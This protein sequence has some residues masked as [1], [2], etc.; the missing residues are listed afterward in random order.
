MSQDSDFSTNRHSVND[1]AKAQVDSHPSRHPDLCFGD[2]NIAILTGSYYFLVHR[3]LLCRHSSVIENATNMLEGIHVRF[4]EGRPTL[5]LHDSP[6]DMCH[7]L[8]AMYDG[9][10]VI[11]LLSPK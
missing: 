10:W 1:S 11:K 2:G 8:L 7:F 3:G 9:M 5:E 4:L 6:Q